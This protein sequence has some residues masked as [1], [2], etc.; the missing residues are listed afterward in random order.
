MKINKIALVGSVSICALSV[1]LSPIK[2]DLPRGS[3]GVI[4]ARAEGPGGE[5]SGAGSGGD[6]EGGGGGDPSGGDRGHGSSSG[7]AGGGQAGGGQASGSSGGAAAGQGGGR[8]GAGGA[9][10]DRHGGRGDSG[11]RGDTSSQKGNGAVESGNKKARATPMRGEDEVTTAL[12]VVDPTTVPAPSKMPSLPVTG[13]VGKLGA[14]DHPTSEIGE[15]ELTWLPPELVRLRE[16]AERGDTQAQFSLAVAY[17]KGL[18]VSKDLSWAARWYGQ[19]AYQGHSEAQYIYGNFKLVGTGTTQDLG[20]A[21]RW[22]KIAAQQGHQKA[23]EASAEL[24]ALLGIGTVYREQERASAFKPA[25][26]ISLFDPPTVEYVQTK[27]AQIGYNPGPTDGLIGPRTTTALEIYKRDRGL[28]IQETLSKE[29]LE[30]IR[31]QPS[32]SERK[33]GSP[34]P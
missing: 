4:E 7:Q 14:S 17:E 9:S 30:S 11:Q 19:A 3:F 16:A 13:D 33:L 21:Y 15:A 29:L 34:A 25:S 27:L 1:M 8:G 12:P 2:S 18:F 10:A 26:G 6:G 23:I 32:G 28:N 5:G 24:E 31:R 20:L 22:M